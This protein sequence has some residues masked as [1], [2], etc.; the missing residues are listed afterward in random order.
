MQLFLLCAHLVGRCWYG[1]YGLIAVQMYLLIIFLLLII[2]S[3][4]FFYKV[5][6]IWKLWQIEN[7]RLLK[8]VVMYYYI[9]CIVLYRSLSTPGLHFR[10]DSISRQL[11]LFETFVSKWINNSSKPC[12]SCYF[13]T[14][15]VHKKTEAT[16]V[17]FPVET[18]TSCDS[19][20]SVFCILLLSVGGCR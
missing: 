18:Q 19:L 12:L 1:Y 6:E 9:K 14:V 7:Y 5:A 17:H 11:L 10:R 2:R 16:S 13:Q 8:I 20:R 3:N 4:I 15:K